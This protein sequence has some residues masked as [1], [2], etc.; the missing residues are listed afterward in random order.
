MVVFDKKGNMVQGQQDLTYIGLLAVDL[1][2][3]ANSYPEG[4]LS[5]NEKKSLVRV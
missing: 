2:S 3:S 5:E 1:S 4:V